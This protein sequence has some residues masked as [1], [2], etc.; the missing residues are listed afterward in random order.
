MTQF[1][2]I[3]LFKAATDK[4]LA[5]LEDVRVQ[6]DRLDLFS[7]NE[8]ITEVPTTSMRFVCRHI[9]IALFCRYVTTLSI[10]KVS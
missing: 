6:C 5:D 2:M 3:S 1:V 10:D 7:P 9:I 4:V 8:D